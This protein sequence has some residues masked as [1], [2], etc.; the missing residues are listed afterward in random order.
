MVQ[1]P[2]Q[3]RTMGCP[4]SCQHLGI[5]GNLH[6]NEGC[7]YTWQ[8]IP[9]WAGSGR[10][11]SCCLSACAF[12]YSALRIDYPFTRRCQQCLPPASA[13]ITH[14]EFMDWLLTRQVV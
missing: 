7:S 12:T 3:L 9:A 4:L 6:Q 10:D 11:F 1:S 14:L 13:T 5:L 2:K 8:V